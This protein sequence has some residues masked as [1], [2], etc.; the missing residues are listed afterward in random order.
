M[1][2]LDTNVLARYLVRDDPA[3]FAAAAREIDRVAEKGERLLLAPIVLCELVW[4]LDSAYGCRRPDITAVLEQI[5]RT[6]QFEVLEKDLVWGAWEDY[7]N[8]KGDFADYYMGR[9]HRQ[10]GAEKTV[11]FD[12]ALIASPFFEV[13]PHR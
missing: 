12:K 4:V 8:G 1:K 10:A 5:L 2:G 13:L 3:Q 7:K 11:T 9:C 6:A